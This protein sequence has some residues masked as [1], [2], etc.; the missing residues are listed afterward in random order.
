[1]T[2]LK[3]I[4]LSSLLNVIGDAILCPRYGVGGAAA[5]T[6]LATLCSVT[7]I[8]RAL[9]HQQLLPRKLHLP[10]LK[11]AKSIGEYMGSRRR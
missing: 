8:I 10:S 6:S 5:A 4:G 7:F 3:I 1:M 2:P 9:K 11:E